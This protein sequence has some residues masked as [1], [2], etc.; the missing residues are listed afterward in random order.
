MCVSPPD[1]C[2]CVCVSAYLFSRPPPISLPITLTLLLVPDLDRVCLT[3]AAKPPSQ[4]RQSERAH[5]KCTHKKGNTLSQQSALPTVC[6][7]VCAR[8]C[9]CACACVRACACAWCMDNVQGLQQHR[10]ALKIHPCALLQ[11]LERSLCRHSHAHL[12]LYQ[13][14]AE[15]GPA[16]ST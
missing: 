6:V 15:L 1:M 3:C 11:H 16:T 2:V 5:S 4:Q 8:V 12:Y 9:A 7:C 10:I 14:A 13:W